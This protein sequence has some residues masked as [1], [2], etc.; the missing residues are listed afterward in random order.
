[1]VT[2]QT[3]SGSRW[4]KQ[5]LSQAREM[6]ETNMADFDPK[7]SSL[8]AVESLIGRSN[9]VNQ[10]IFIKKEKI[11]SKT[12]NDTSFSTI[13]LPYLKQNRGKQIGTK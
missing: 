12:K 13:K 11:M 10:S 3:N 4:S 1:M 7:S 2:N 6:K 9:S 5:Q 8:M